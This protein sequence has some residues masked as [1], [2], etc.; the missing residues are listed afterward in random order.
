MN[1]F[2]SSIV[3]AAVLAAAAAGCG[4]GTPVSP[5]MT[6]EP[7]AAAATPVAGQV[8]AKRAAAA[9]EIAA[10]QHLEGEIGPG[11]LYTLDRPANWNGA[12]VIWVHGYAPPCAPV[13]LPAIA[14][15][16]DALLAQGFGVATSSFSENGYALAE[17][18]R[19]THQLSGLF[20]DNLGVPDRTF[21]IGVS[22]GG[23]IGLKLI[24]TYPQEYSGALLVS[25]VVGGTEAEVQYV[26]DT[27]VLFDCLYPGVLPGGLFDVPDCGTPFP[28]GA[29]VGA[30]QANPQAL[31]ALLC[32]NP[33]LP[34]ANPTEAVTS[35]ATALG[36]QWTGAEDLFDRTH[37][38]SLYGNDD[39]TYACPALPQASL[40]AIN[41]CVTRYSITPD[42]GAFLRRN[43]EPDGAL[44][45]PVLTLHNTRDP[46][47]P[48][49]HEARYRD[50][51]AQ[52]GRLAYLLQRSK[53]S[54]G[55]V[56]FSGPEL[57]GAFAD[58][59]AWASSGQKPPA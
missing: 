2:R 54:Y 25:G 52:R 36:F 33:R 49:F 11:A 31:G 34:F 39:R 4:R 47:V 12:L 28:Q 6:T 32:L 37:G 59:V 56:N 1:R 14:P 22:L 44:S 15:L 7:G 57:L 19:Q 20:K 21:L 27:R 5:R 58:L 50:K 10:A 30:I 24:E 48:L 17:A 40:D 43:Y 35:V 53:D 13:T 9:P 45:V 8:S 26:G 16:R 55:H 18:V 29:V 46:V 51:V 41:A 42:A 38:H 23:I 3:A